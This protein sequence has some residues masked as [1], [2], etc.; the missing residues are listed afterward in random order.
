MGITR[1]GRLSSARSKKSN[2]ISVAV[3]E[4][5]EKK[6]KK[7]ILIGSPIGYVDTEY[8]VGLHHNNVYE[9]HLS[10]WYPNE[11]IKRGYMVVN[12]PNIFLA[13]KKL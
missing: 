9:R 7:I 6:A 10:G 12:D 4:K 2:S 13:F 5:I 8:A 1:E 3:L 11:F